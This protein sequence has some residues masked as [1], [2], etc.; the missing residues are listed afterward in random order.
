[1]VSA[2]I[3]VIVSYYGPF[4]NGLSDECKSVATCNFDLFDKSYHLVPE[5]FTEREVHTRAWWFFQ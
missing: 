4:L 2:P 3:L 5:E 1:M